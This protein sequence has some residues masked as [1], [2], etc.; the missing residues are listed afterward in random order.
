[1][2]ARAAGPGG[3]TCATEKHPAIRADRAA[4]GGVEQRQLLRRPE[5]GRI[6]EPKLT[7]VRSHPGGPAAASR[8][9]G[10]GPRQSPARG[11]APPAPSWRP[12][13]SVSRSRPKLRRSRFIRATGSA[14]CHREAGAAGGAAAR[15]GGVVLPGLPSPSVGGAPTPQTAVTR[16]PPPCAQTAPGSASLTGG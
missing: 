8:G 16:H 5:G 15:Y 10:A 6:A 14:G 4:G 12:L 9:R 7:F 13:G 2:L 3:A 11:R 1:M